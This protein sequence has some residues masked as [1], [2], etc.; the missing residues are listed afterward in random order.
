[1]SLAPEAQFPRQIEE[2][3]R[4]FRAL[5]DEGRSPD[6]IV[7]V[8]DSAGGGLVLSAM[9]A[10]RREG[11][12][13]PASV[14][15]LSP[16]VDCAGMSDTHHSVEATD[17]V[18][19][20]LALASLPVILRLYAPDRDARDPAVSPV[21]ASYVGAPPLLVHAGSREVL[22]GDAARLCER[23]RDD[24]AEAHL[25]VHDGMFHLFHMHGRLAAARRAYADLA[26]F[27]ASTTGL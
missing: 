5:L 19:G 15:L 25:R 13:A 23:A 3:G 1:Y 21:Y 18:F 20:D 4:V 12:P 16:L 22:L 8:G 7:L 27:V 9:T 10:W 17:P 2:I 14:A 24:G 6:T 11:V 26:R